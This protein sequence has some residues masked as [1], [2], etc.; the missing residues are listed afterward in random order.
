MLQCRSAYLSFVLWAGKEVWCLHCMCSSFCTCVSHLP[1]V[2]SKPIVLPH[3]LQPG[4]CESD[5]G[6]VSTKCEICVGNKCVSRVRPFP[7]CSL[8]CFLTA[9]L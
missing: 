6:C 1:S 8:Q 3:T 2:T 4:N 9:W 5:G 7:F